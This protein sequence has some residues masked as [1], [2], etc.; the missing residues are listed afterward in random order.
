MS[1]ALRG[2]LL[3][4]AL[5]PLLSGCLT[6]AA[7]AI[8]ADGAAEDRRAREDYHRPV[9]DA[10]AQDGVH[11]FDGP[12]GKATLTVANGRVVVDLADCAT[13]SGPLEP[14]STAD[15]DQ[16]LWDAGEPKP[17]WTRVWSLV[18]DRIEATGARCENLRGAER[19]QMATAYRGPDRGGFGSV[20]FVQALRTPPSTF[21]TRGNQVFAR[22]FGAP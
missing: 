2:L 9:L 11:V 13:F 7:A 16:F 3:T 18:P 12:L 1:P 19:I 15:Y 14:G 21:F 8:V 20:F 5:S 22:A 4:L 10:F 17:D 6:I